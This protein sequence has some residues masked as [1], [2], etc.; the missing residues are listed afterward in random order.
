VPTGLAAR[1]SPRPRT[2]LPYRRSVLP[3]GLRVVT[4]A[5]PAARSVSVALFVGVG[6]RHED[7]AHRGMSHILEH[8]AFK[9]TQAF[10]QP[11]ALSSAI[12]ACGGSAN[13]ST[14]RELTVYTAKVP[15]ERAATAYQVVAELALR[16]LLRRRDLAAEKPVIVDEIRMY[17]DSPSDHVF[18]LFDEL[19]FG[20]HPL[21]REIAGSPGSV[22]R[23]TREVVVDHWLRWYRPERAVLSAA[24]AVEHQELVAAAEGWWDGMRSHPAAERLSSRLEAPDPARPG[25]LRVRH[26][27]LGG[28]V[29]DHRRF[30]C[31]A[32][33]RI[34]GVSG[35]VPAR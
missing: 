18:A 9:G 11:G 30:S 6:S 8:M 21:G 31:A 23:A 16:P 22:R 19:L 15:R 1:R 17:I 4:Q 13:A 5:M 32:S 27:R 24:G 29:V 34:G 7:D 12:E 2:E 10:P 26:R 25:A 14:D 28:L 35:T 3:N 20:D 33:A